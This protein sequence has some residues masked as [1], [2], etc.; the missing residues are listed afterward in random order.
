MNLFS[1]LTNAIYAHFAKKS[2]STTKVHIKFSLLKNQ[3]IS[4]KL[5]AAYSLTFI[6]AVLGIIVGVEIA[7]RTEQRAIAIQAEAHEDI[8]TITHFQASLLDFSYWK[9][10]FLNSSNIAQT[11]LQKLQISHTKLQEDWLIFIN[12]EEL[13]EA[14]EESSE[15]I[16]ETE[17]L[18]AL[19]IV[20]DHAD[21]F[22]Q[23][24]KSWE[25]I[26]QKSSEIYSSEQIKQQL[27]LIEQGDAIKKF[28][29]FLTKIQ[30]LADATEEEEEEAN[31]LL[32]QASNRQLQI[33]I[34]S[35]LLSGTCGL[36]LMYWTSRVLMSPLKSMT[37]ETQKAINS[38]NFDLKVDTSMQDEIGTL[39][40]TFNAYSDFVKELLLS[41]QAANQKLEQTLTELQSAQIQVIQSEKMSSLGQLVAG[42]A[43][44][45]NNPVNFVQ[46][47]IYHVE[48]YVNDLLEIP[49]F[50]QQFYPE[51]PEEIESFLE[52][53]E[54]EF[55]RED[56]PKILKA[57]RVGTNRITDIVL[58]LRN[59]SRTDDSK[60]KKMDVHEGIE[61]TLMILRHRTDS[62][63]K[64]PKIE[65][66]KKYSELPQ[67]NCYPGLL[68]QVFMN[69]LANA[70]DAL[71]EKLEGQS[72]E[73]K[74]KETPHITIRTGLT[75]DNK[76]IQVAIADNGLGIPDKVRSRIFDPFFTTK[77]IGK[78]TGMGL[79]ISYQL[80]TEKHQGQFRCESKPGQGTEMII[81]IPLALGHESEEKKG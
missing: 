62:K 50:Y 81:E 79:S 59:F 47:N 21:E 8:E 11:D 28:G 40:H 63:G 64:R 75:Q 24:L 22:E 15:R 41:S 69:L 61:N 68:N 42:V 66:E 70:I 54:M 58:A 51:P 80:V 10:L 72:E 12:S 43:H 14:G 53:I 46:G 35:A 65:I 29:D 19:S 49:E 20:D 30:E 13:V 27:R 7:R 3:S 9:Q 73:E 4:S 45:I 26:L 78:G 52:D 48:T 5:F 2:H 38:Q 74:Q 6:M 31:F 77:E 18:V 57:M 56:L 32:E 76:S 44:E 36:L 17:S 23:Y 25:I 33:I 16:T 34:F 55:V 67:I 71:E 1:I 60:L 39:A 37:L